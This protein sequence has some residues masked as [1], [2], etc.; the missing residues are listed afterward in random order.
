MRPDA[1][2]V[3]AEIVVTVMLIIW[4]GFIIFLVVDL[5]SLLYEV[6]I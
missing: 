3:V 4:I 2:R 6:Y 5:W 1:E